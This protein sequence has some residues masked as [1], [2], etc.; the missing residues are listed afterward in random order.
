MESI[1]DFHIFFKKSLLLIFLL[2]FVLTGCGKDQDIENYRAN[3]TQFFENIQTINDAI[4]QL[5]PEAEN[6][7]DQL[8]P[9]LD[10][11]E[12]SFT[13]MASLEVPEEFTGVAELAA[14][15]SKYMTEAVSYYHQA[16]EGEEYDETSA[17]IAY[18]NYQFANKRLQY[19]IQILHGNI[20]E[21]IFTYEDD[22]TDTEVDT[23]ADMDVDVDTENADTD[24]NTDADMDTGDG[25]DAEKTD[26][27]N[28]TDDEVD[29]ASDTN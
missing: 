13:Q 27:D 17:D 1:P 10:S 3:M 24:M 29:S 15:A 20:P 18:Q 12:T 19:I 25:T 26:S 7:G 14:D 23:D 11:L 2:I 8:L 6:V 16:Y 5:D 22:E 21:E 28:G 9:L 4:N